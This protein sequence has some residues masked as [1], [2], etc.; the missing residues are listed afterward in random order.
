MRHAFRAARRLMTPALLG[1]AGCAS[2][3]RD[4]PPLEQY[5]LGAGRA[6]VPADAQALAHAPATGL[7]IGVRRLDLAAYLDVP[8]I[9]V[10]QGANRIIVS[11]FHRWGEDLG[12][13]INRQVARHLH[14]ASSV[15][16]VDVAPWAVRARHD[17]LVQLH[18]TRFE[19]VADALASEG[20]A[21]IVASWQIVRPG[22]GAVLARGETD[23]ERRGWTV[24][25][26]AALV[27]L[28]DDGLAQVAGDVLNCLARVHASAP[29]VAASTRD[30]GAEPPQA[31]S[32][33]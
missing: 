17:Y 13:A 19:G 33:V 23:A 25:D 16:A 26:Y 27:L 32:C 11:D 20:S 29:A 10:R 21:R 4:A 14:D 2:L 8:A 24:D 12:D 30:M 28:L 5:V 15:S 31:V 22:D 3:G 1:L 7:R 9:V 18:V 6:P